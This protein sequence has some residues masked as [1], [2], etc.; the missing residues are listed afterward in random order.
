MT[1][2]NVAVL[3][4]RLTKIMHELPNLTISKEDASRLLTDVIPAIQKTSWTGLQTRYPA[5]KDAFLRL[6]GTLVAQ[7]LREKTI[8]LSPENPRPPFEAPNGG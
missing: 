1:S 7:R 8:E 5:G 2:E 6:F 4:I 3:A